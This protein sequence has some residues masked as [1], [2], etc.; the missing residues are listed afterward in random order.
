MRWDELT[1]EE[2]AH[3]TQRRLRQA[4]RRGYARACWDIFQW[5]RDLPAVTDGL[6]AEDRAKERDRVC[7]F[8]LDQ[9]T[10]EG[11]ERP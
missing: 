2:R 5:M 1:E 7:N 10:L 8:I 11:G 9:M 3:I 6:S 4:E